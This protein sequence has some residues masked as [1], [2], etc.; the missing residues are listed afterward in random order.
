MKILATAAAACLAAGLAP[1][2]DAQV[3]ALF[4]D[5]AG[6]V[7]SFDVPDGWLMT[8]GFPIALTGAP[9]VVGLHPEEDFSLWVGLMAPA[10]VETREDAGEYLRD[11]GGRLVD[12][13]QVERT[14][15]AAL[16]ALPGFGV[17]GRGTRE[18]Q[19]VD[20]AAIGAPLPEGGWALAVFVG[21]NGAREVYAEALEALRASFEAAEGDR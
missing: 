16:G 4:E 9:R 6:P 10:G 2:A 8:S 11:L 3:R 21:E 15:E 17:S 20:F 13:A 5:G 14:G 19:P 18:G 1:P 7:F 12:G